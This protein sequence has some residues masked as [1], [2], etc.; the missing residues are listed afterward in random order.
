MPGTVLINVL[1]FENL[2]VGV[3]TA[4]PHGLRLP[5]RPN[6][7]PDRV[8]TETG[9]YT[10]STD[11]TDVTVTR[12]AD[13]PGP[14]VRVEVWAFHSIIDTVPPGTTPYTPPF[15]VSDVSTSGSAGLIQTVNTRLPVDAIKTTPV[16]STLLLINANTGANP[17]IMS[18]TFGLGSVNPIDAGALRL[19]VDG[20]PVAGTNQAAGSSF[21][22]SAA[23]SFKT[24][25]LVA[26]AHTFSVEWAL[27]GGISFQ[28]RPVTFPDREH[29]S[30]TI[31]EVAI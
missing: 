29:A 31:F 27:V 14:D 7:I 9:P 21:L 4:L 5:N 16:F 17:V 24:A 20:T 25:P 11:D 30:L 3:P 1:D 15:I 18:A 19:V 10:V 22:G 23:V 12:T 2:V 6:I 26:G 28:I 8:R 13:S